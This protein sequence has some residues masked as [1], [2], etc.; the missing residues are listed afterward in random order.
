MIVFSEL[1][2]YFNHMLLTFSLL[3]NSTHT[4]PCFEVYTVQ[5]YFIF[6]YIYFLSTGCPTKYDSRE[7][8][9]RSSLIFYIICSIFNSLTL[10]PKYCLPFLGGFKTMLEI[11]QITR[12]DNFDDLINFSEVLCY[13][14]SSS[15]RQSNPWRYILKSNPWR[16]ILKSN[17]WRY[18]LKS[19]PWRYILKSLKCY[20]S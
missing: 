14:G 17:P 13:S 20:V 1:E 4:A 11:V 10:F 19:N 3:E 7:V 15:K 5:L 6:L 8:A 9:W 16:H 18:I 2:F 12:H